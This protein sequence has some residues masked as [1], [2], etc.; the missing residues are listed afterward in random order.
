[1]KKIALLGASRGLGWAL[2][3]QLLR[4]YEGSDFLLVSR[5]IDQRKNELGPRTEILNQDFS[6]EKMDLEFIKKLEEFEPNVLVY[7]AGGGPYGKLQSKKWSD[8]QWALR[9]SFLYPAELTH[10]ILSQPEN[11]SQLQ[12]I[13]LIGSSVAEQKPDPLASSY[14]A[15]KHALK[16]FVDSVNAEQSP[17][18]KLLLFSPPYMLT[19][20]LPANSH[21]RLNDRAENPLVVAERLIEYIEKA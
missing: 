21:P 6:K 9:T 11:W 18:A 16:G 7:M 13:V 4:N 17:F 12:K 10:H 2:Y 15:A 1:M 14:A 8:H 3:Q 19:D 20:M 5:K